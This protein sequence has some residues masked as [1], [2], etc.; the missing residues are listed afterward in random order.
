M[1]VACR[2]PGG[3]DLALPRG[4]GVPPL[5]V[6]LQGPPGTARPPLARNFVASR[7][8]AGALRSSVDKTL[9]QLRETAADEFTQRD[10][11]VTEVHDAQWL[12]WYETHKTLSVVLDRIVFALNP[13]SWR[14]F[15]A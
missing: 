3:M 13:G 15:Q 11:G 7:E 4:A 14:N 8:P 5:V 9:R 12:Q 10:Y 2:W 1:R 6:T